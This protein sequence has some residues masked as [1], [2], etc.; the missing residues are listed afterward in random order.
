M[1]KKRISPFSCMVI[2]LA[3]AASG[4]AAPKAFQVK[5]QGETLLTA[6]SKGF[7]V[8][9]RIKT[10]ETAAPR[11]IDPYDQESSCTGARSPC[12][13]V[14]SLKI[15]VN[16]KPVFV[17]RSVFCDLADLNDAEISIAG[18]TAKLTLTGGDASESYIAKIYFDK[19][20]VTRRTVA[21]GEDPDSIIQD[22][23]YRIATLGD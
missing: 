11:I 8:R 4:F 2:L 16:G 10:H 13:L 21:G 12:S 1:K 7:A 6:A 20:N 23:R 19:E 3:S 17:W 14:D 15:S 5:V 18:T 22:T 9:I